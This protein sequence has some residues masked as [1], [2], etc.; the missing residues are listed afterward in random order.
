M[1]IGACDPRWSLAQRVKIVGSTTACVAI[2]DGENAI[3]NVG[4]LGDAAR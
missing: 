3:V 4:N 1:L 2:L